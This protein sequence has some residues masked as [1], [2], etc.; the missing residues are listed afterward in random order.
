[1]EKIIGNYYADKAKIRYSFSGLTYDTV[2]V[3]VCPVLANSNGKPKL[4]AAVVRITGPNTE[5]GI[6]AIDRLAEIVAVQ[7]NAGAGIYTG[8]K[9]L[10][11]DS[12]YARHS[13]EVQDY[14]AA[15]PP[16]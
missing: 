9:N 14:W 15:N 1:M 7:L 13:F 2:S 8:P 10:S 4:G 5:E 6:A 11:I 16:K 12:P 3:G